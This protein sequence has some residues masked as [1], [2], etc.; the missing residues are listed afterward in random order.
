MDLDAWER[1]A[2]AFTR[3]RHMHGPRD[4]GAKLPQRDRAVVAEY[5]SLSA[6][7]EGCGLSGEGEIGCVR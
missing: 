1:G 3:N 7:E 6:R 5:R 4:S 2:T